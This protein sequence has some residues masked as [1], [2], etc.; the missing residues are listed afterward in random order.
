MDTSWVHNPLSHNGN[1][2]NGGSVLYDSRDLK[3]TAKQTI[4]TFY[5][6]SVQDL[7]GPKSGKNSHQHCLSCI[8]HLFCFG[9][10]MAFFPISLKN[11][12]EHYLSKE[13]ISKTW[14]FAGDQ[15]SSPQGTQVSSLN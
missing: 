10:K 2:T 1:S 9:K 11:V 15:T 6:M 7:N 5:R 3:D 4:S 8:L 13:G 14:S 12:L